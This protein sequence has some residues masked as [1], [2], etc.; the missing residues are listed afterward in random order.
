MDAIIDFVLLLLLGAV[1]GLLA[2][3]LG[4]GGGLIIV[5]VLTGFL[6]LQDVAEAHAIK[7]AIGTSLATIVLT[8]LASIRAH[9]RY[10]AV[11]W[12]AFARL[13]PGILVGALG[14]GLLAGALPGALL[15]RIFSV[16]VLLMA[17]QLLLN[18]RPRAA[19]GL[20]GWGGVALAGT[21]I[22][23]V[24]A[25]VGIGGGAMTVP[26]LIWCS[27]S[28]RQAVATSAACGLPIALAG[29]VGFAI[30]GLGVVGLPDFCVG[31]LYLP[32]LV[33]ITL[34][35][36]W[37]APLG[38]RLAHRLPMRVLRQFFAVFLLILGVNMLLT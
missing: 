17:A 30:S 36:V 16:F 7:L 14:G 19:G 10:H 35:S 28:T 20:P 5:P 37:V 2:G 22:G 33:N 21:V 31:Y 18:L 29:S 9:H 23:A 11:M 8:S 1:V 27:A 12:P 24:S 15:Q 26:F 32:A 6:S 38:A 34:A 3:L 25:L 4:I 13:A